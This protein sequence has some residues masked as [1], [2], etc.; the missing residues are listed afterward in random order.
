MNLV[1]NLQ[2]YRDAS[3]ERGGDVTGTLAHGSRTDEDNSR[4]VMVA[5]L[6]VG[7][8]ALAAGLINVKVAAGRG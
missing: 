3:G 1:T 5:F 2:S 4:H 8:L 7:V 6:A